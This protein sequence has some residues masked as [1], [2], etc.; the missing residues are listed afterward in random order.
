MKKAVL[1]TIGILL[2]LIII[3][4]IFLP[5]PKFKNVQEQLDFAISS[6]QYPLAENLAIELIQKDSLNIE[7]YVVYLKQHFN[8]PKTEG[9]YGPDR[10][11]KPIHLF[12]AKRA[13]SNNT[14]ISDIGKYGLGLYNSLSDNN[15]L[16]LTDYLK[17]GNKKLKYL[18]NSIGVI[19]NRLN[20]LDSAEIFFNKEIVNNG[21]LEGAYYNLSRLLKR[22]GRFNELQSLSNDSIAN[23][24][25]SI[26]TEREVSFYFHRYGKYVKSILI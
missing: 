10:D 20:K 12:F 25:L 13:K 18:N 11:D 7:Y 14:D 9:R 22:A 2:G 5:D 4:N 6:K 8:R 24:Y 23:L 19:F 21:N 26:S 1:I 15:E 16:A 3:L 17:V